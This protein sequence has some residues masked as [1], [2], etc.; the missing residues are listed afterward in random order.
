MVRGFGERL[1]D[2]AKERNASAFQPE[3][4]PGFPASDC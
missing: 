1:D 3:A 2:V 4:G